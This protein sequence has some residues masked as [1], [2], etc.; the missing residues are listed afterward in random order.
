MKVKSFK[1]NAS[2]LEEGLI[3]ELK[4]MI[5]DNQELFEDS[6]VA[7]MP[8]AH[9]TGGIP[10]GFTMTVPHKRIAPDFISSDIACGMTSYLIKDWQPTK[11][12]LK[13]LS[14]IIR[15]LVQVNRRFRIDT[16]NE[17]I[18]DL[19]T[20]GGGNHFL[21]IG[22]NGND[23]L[24]TVHSGSRGLGG[25]TYKKWKEK[26]KQQYKDLLKETTKQ[27]LKEIEPRDRQGW[28]KNNKPKPRKIDFID[29]ST[30]EKL[31]EEFI[32]DYKKAY[33]RA[34]SNR[35]FILDTI[36][37]YFD[38]WL[39]GETIV[40]PHNYIDFEEETW[41]IRKG[42]IKATKGETVIIPINMRDGII[43]GEVSDRGE[44]NNSL[45]HGAGRILSR[46]KAF[47]NLDMETFKEDMK[48]VISST[49][50]QE[51]LDES[52]RA[53]KDIET[54]LNDIGEDLTNI[55]VFK[56]VFNYKGVEK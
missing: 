39:I 53:Y 29:L 30:D 5:R 35:Q 14:L 43:I 1:V 41:V 22:V 4:Q 46:T 49:V 20:L 16:Y 54:I 6:E 37:S 32:K 24:I 38:K 33:T 18:T 9:K 31:E 21:E 11:S 28:L 2:V 48:D 47:E 7:L 34:L 3:K 45:P 50:V 13:T 36:K 10:V 17:R 25:I 15:D 42:S 44:F 51:T 19:G 27:M 26:A 55:R 40:C 8:D 23:T 52:P 12:E 56:T